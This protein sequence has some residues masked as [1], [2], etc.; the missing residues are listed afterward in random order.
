MKK[1]KHFLIFKIIGFIGICVAIIGLVN[2]INGFGD[3]SNN[4]FIIG[5]FMFTFGLFIG[6]VCLIIGFRPEISKISTR[7]AKYILEENK[8]DLKDLSKT[9]AEIASGA[10]SETVKAVKEGLD[11]EVFCKYCG[12]RIDDDS[13]FCKYCGKNV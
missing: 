2:I 9:G 13:K 10:I 1:P 11:T 5:A 4:R 12:Q 6:I 8:E 7:S 3:F